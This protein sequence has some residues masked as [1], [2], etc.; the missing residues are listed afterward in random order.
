MKQ[1]KEGDFIVLLIDTNKNI[2]NGEFANALQ[3]KSLKEAILERYNNSQGLVLTHQIGL[4]PI[5][6]IFLLG[7]LS[8][9]EGEYFPLA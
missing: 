8:I 2:D 7:S 3:A 6:S 4:V 5:D 9:S 1:Q